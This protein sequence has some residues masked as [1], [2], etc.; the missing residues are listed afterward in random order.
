MFLDEV[1]K[2]AK[3]FLEVTGA[4]CLFYA[5]IFSVSI[6]SIRRKK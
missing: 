4:V 6:I 3:P 2:I 1:L 5:A